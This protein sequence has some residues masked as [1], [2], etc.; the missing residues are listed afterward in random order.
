MA[1]KPLKKLL[2]SICGS[3]EEYRRVRDLHY[4]GKQMEDIR[5][6]CFSHSFPLSV[7]AG[8]LLLPHATLLQLVRR[9]CRPP[10]LHAVSCV[11]HRDVLSQCE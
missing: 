9:N 8:P 10:L 11:M 3:K 1:K 5:K 4:F 6:L 2:V 7:V